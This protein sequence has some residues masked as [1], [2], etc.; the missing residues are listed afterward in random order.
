MLVAAWAVAVLHGAAVLFMVTGSLLALRR[1]RLLYLHTPV[2]LAILAVNLAGQPCPLTELELAL[3]G[4]A[5]AAPYSG[6]FLGH[7]ALAPFGVGVH[8]V[9]A[10]V[11]IYLIAVVPNVVGYGLALRGV[12]V[13]RSRDGAVTPSR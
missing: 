8:T 2:A 13:R 4:A 9:G 6:G 3:R 10:Q 1:P 7:Y 12:R 11:G 5:G